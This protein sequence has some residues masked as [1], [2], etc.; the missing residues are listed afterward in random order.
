MIFAIGYAL[1]IP[2]NTSKPDVIVFA[3][4]SIV[5]KPIFDIAYLSKSTFLYGEPLPNY[6]LG[7]TI[8]LWLIYHIAPAALAATIWP[9]GFMSAICGAVI[10]SITF[11]IWRKL[12]VATKQAVIISVVV[13]LVPSFI[14]ESIIGEVYALQFCTML[15]SVYMFLS[16]RIIISTFFFLLSCLVSPLSGLAFGLFFLNGF[17]K[18]TLY[19]ALFVGGAS[20]ILYM[21]I[22]FLIDANL[23]K[24]L[25]PPSEIIE[26]RGL[27]YRTAALLFF[28]IINFNFFFL[29]LIKGIKLSSSE[30]Y[31]ISKFLFFAT[32]PQLILLFQGATFFI[33]LGS[34]QL[35]VFW[36]LAFPVGL[37]TSNVKFSNPLLLTAIL[38]SATIAIFLFILPNTTLGN[39]RDEAGFWLKENGYS[40]IPVVGPYSVGINIVK[41]RDGFNLNSVNSYY[42]N[43][44]RPSNEDLL[45]TNH[46]RLIIAEAKK[47]YFRVLLSNI[48]FPGLEMNNYDATKEIVIGTTKK[49]FENEYVILFL[50]DKVDTHNELEEK[51]LGTEKENG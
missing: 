43:K 26:S 10:V 27:L 42:I 2:F 46:G 5:D 3:L 18:N 7:H 48:G 4:R 13:G 50:W 41:S 34:F 17:D 20:L 21:F 40:S 15:L 44:S 32:L 1:I 39:G 9:A 49:I 6:H 24:L 35:P 37:V 12:G 8:I 31:N 36:A 22:Y 45:K 28:V 25:N 11:L 19:K 29:F 16:G 23:L 51:N 47:P 38:G 14:E 30:Y 33:E